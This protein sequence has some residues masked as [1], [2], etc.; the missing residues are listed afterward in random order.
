MDAIKTTNAA[1]SGTGNGLGFITS[2]QN[3]EGGWPFSG[4]APATA[5]SQIVPTAYNLITL[6]HFKSL[7]G[8]QTNINNG[9][10]WL[11][12]QQKVGG[13]F[14]EGMAGNVLETAL[15]YQALVTEVGSNDSTAVLALDF[16]IA[17]QM[18]YGGWGGDVFRTALVM[19]TLPSA[20]MADTDKDGV[21]DDVENAIGYI[22]VNNRVVL[23]NPLVADSRWLSD[24]GNGNSLGG[25]TAADVR[26]GYINQSAT[27]AFSGVGVRP[28]YGWSITSGALPPGLIVDYKGYYSGVPTELGSYASTHV[29]TDAIGVTASVAI[30]FDIVR[31]TANGHG[32]DINGDGVVDAADVD[33]AQRISLGLLAPTAV[34]LLQADVAPNGAWDGAI[35]SAD[36]FR[37]QRKALGLEDF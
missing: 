34:Q 1:Y 17:Q 27:G 19:Q 7:F 9:I 4:D 29:M 3:A 15:A 16:L 37:I 32:G 6:N 12:S 20:R 21:P 10:A 13:G 25:V 14:G 11:K 2:K 31:T 28:Y 26:T 23:S 24:K 33:M 8:V 5:Q 30:R 35:D 18:G 22:L 36:V